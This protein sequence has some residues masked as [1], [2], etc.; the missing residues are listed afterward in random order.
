MAEGLPDDIQPR[1]VRITLMIEGNAFL[2]HV[3]EDSEMFFFRR[4]LFR[5][6]ETL[7]LRTRTAR[8]LKLFRQQ[9]DELTRLKT[10]EDLTT[11]LAEHNP[12]ICAVL[13]HATPESPAEVEVRGEV[14]R[15]PT[16]RF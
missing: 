1:W 16:A 15:N 10:Q 3:P 6:A 14:S 13:L 11:V 4:L 2:T 9:S 12:V 7:G 8:G 5:R